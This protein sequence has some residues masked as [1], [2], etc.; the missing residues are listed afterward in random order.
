MD[1]IFK[2][3]R[4]VEGKQKKVALVTCYFQPNYG[5]MLQALATQEMLDIMNVP[6]ETICIDGLKKE[7]H[8][9]KMRYF[10]SRMFSAD[11]I[12]DKLGYLKLVAAQKLDKKLGKNIALRKKCFEAYSKS[13]FRVSRPYSSKSELSRHI[14]D[15][16]AF[17]VG[18]DQL[19][20]P[21]NIAADYYTLSFVPDEVR[22]IAYAT[23]F[24]VSILPKEQAEAAKQFIPRIDH[25]SVREQSG[26]KLIKDLTGID[27]KLV[28]D[29][30]L[31]LTKKQWGD[32]I[33]DKRIIKGKYIFCY[34]L[35][36]NRF[37]RECALFLQKKTG[38]KIVA[39]QHLDMYIRSDDTFADETPYQIDPDGFVNLI[40]Y[41]E[42]VCTDSFHGTVFSLIHHKNFFTFRRFWKA[43]TMSTNSRIDSLLNVLGCEYRL[44]ESTADFKKALS[45]PLDTGSVEARLNDFRKDSLAFLKD[46]LQGFE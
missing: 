27:A 2:E 13:K 44:I 7:I 38:Y 17:L 37:S 39:L 11:V 26:Q 29:P 3:V 18:S 46:A 31:L 45:T 16:T 9:A 28:C 32:L 43:S 4:R 33:E 25:L 22:K 20:L 24:G 6:N 1:R 12:K 5:S 19:W 42:F 40:R 23:S 10:K 35:G 34:F 30:T 8:D 21:S 15:Y 41:A 14:E 36:D